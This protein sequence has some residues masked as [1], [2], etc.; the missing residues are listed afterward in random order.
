M[1]TPCWHI[2]STWASA[3]SFE[4]NLHNYT[5]CS[6]VKHMPQTPCCSQQNSTRRSSHINARGK[7]TL[8]VEAASSICIVWDMMVSLHYRYDPQPPMCAH[9]RARAH[10]RTTPPPLKTYT[11]RQE[12]SL[13]AKDDL[14]FYNA[15]HLLHIFKLIFLQYAKPVEYHLIA[16]HK[17]SFTCTKQDS[18]PVSVQALW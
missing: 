11:Q 12:I 6:P 13:T 18:P 15:L 8:N 10:T 1:R 2:H 17:F 16:K 7:K 14:N 9:T 4:Y 5:S 3:D